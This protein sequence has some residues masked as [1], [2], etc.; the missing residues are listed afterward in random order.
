MF[1]IRPKQ[2]LY[3]GILPKQFSIS[4]QTL[5]ILITL[6]LA[7]ADPFEMEK[8]LINLTFLALQTGNKKSG[9]HLMFN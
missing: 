3:F 8:Y 5:A 2:E 4:A 6:H 7:L 9:I 1:N